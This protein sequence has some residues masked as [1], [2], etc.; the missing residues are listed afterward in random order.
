M[1]SIAGKQSPMPA[2]RPSGRGVPEPPRNLAPKPEKTGQA[3]H[4]RV[5]Q[6]AEA[7]FRPAMRRLPRLLPRLSSPRHRFPI[8]LLDRNDYKKYPPYGILGGAMETSASFEARS[9]P[10][11]YPTTFKIGNSGRPP[12]ASAAGDIPGHCL[13]NLEVGRRLYGAEIAARRVTRTKTATC[14]S[15]PCR[16]C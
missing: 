6:R 15:Y 16:R 8:A 5:C 12:A 11:S 3:A 10:S 13:R 1:L 7:D 9:A 4:G 2:R 14:P